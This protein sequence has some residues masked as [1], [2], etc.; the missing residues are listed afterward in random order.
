MESRTRSTWKTTIQLATVRHLGIHCP[1]ASVNLNLRMR[2]LAGANIVGS[3]SEVQHSCKSLVSTSTFVLA[4]MWSGHRGGSAPVDPN[5]GSILEPSQAPANSCKIFSPVL[6]DGACPHS[7]KP[8][9]LARAENLAC[10]LREAL[11][12]TQP[13]S[14]IRYTRRKGYRGPFSL[15]TLRRNEGHLTIWGGF[16]SSWIARALRKCVQLGV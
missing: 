9:R 15:G 6:V 8:A 3:L 10:G 16:V 13:L 11:A 4:S 5:R 14:L 12:S 2:L 1:L 7:S